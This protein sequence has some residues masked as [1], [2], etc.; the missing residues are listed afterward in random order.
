MDNLKETI[1]QHLDNIP[2][3]L[4]LEQKYERYVDKFS[5][6]ERIQLML[7]ELEK[8]EK[9]Y[10]LLD[11]LADYIETADGFQNAFDEFLENF[12]ML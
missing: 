7:D 9:Y 12:N 3:A 5:A 8:S 1:D 10:F 4:P 2:E 11:H 6:Q